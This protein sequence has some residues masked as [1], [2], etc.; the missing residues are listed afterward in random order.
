MV[1]KRYAG[2][3]PDSLVPTL[4]P[5]ALAGAQIGAEEGFVLSRV[6]GRTSVGEICLLVPF[7]A[8]VTVTILKRLFS[9]GAIDIPGAERPGAR[10]VTDVTGLE[11]S[12]EQANRIDEVFGALETRGLFELLETTRA[13]DK[14]EIKR[15]YFKMSKEF[16]PDRYFGKNIGPYRD[17]LSRIFQSVKAAFELLSDDSRRTAYEES[18]RSK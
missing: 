2:L 1:A 3:G 6:D 8:E 14:K 17:R 18:T 7:D 13:A 4:V 5:A 15:A 9:L 11:L 16:H 10:P 12:P